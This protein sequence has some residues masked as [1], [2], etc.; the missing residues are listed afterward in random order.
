MKY[1]KLLLIALIV[2]GG[3]IAL[4]CFRGCVGDNSKESLI[5]TT[6]V[7]KR[8]VYWKGKIKKMCSDKNWT[9]TGFNTLANGM[10]DDRKKGNIDKREESALQNLLFAE[11]CTYLKEQT[12]TLFSSNEY[13]KEERERLKGI[14]AFLKKKEKRYGNNG[15]LNFV[16]GLFNA[17]NKLLNQLSF[18]CTASY[19]NPLRRYPGESV[20]DRKH[21]IKSEKYYKEYFCKCSDIERQLNNLESKRRQAEYA[22]YDKLEKTIEKHY[23]EKEGDI[24]AL[25]SD[26]LS[27]RDISTNNEASRRLKE[28]AD[29]YIKKFDTYESE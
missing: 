15:E 13:P 4:N 11:S 23:E 18:Y 12:K 22:Y 24:S 14:L 8:A 19:S 1:I 10:P 2:V 27:F 29:E 21:R 6:L 20:E 9:E 7:S 16:A 17:Y 3:I 28:F 5:D 26:D 25:R